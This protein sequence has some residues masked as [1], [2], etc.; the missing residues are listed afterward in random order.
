MI[1]RIKPDDF[2]KRFDIVGCFLLHEGSFVLLHRHAH[3]ASGNTWGLP[4]GK[5]DAGETLSAAVVREAQEETGVELKEEDVQFFNSYYVR[6]GNFDLG[7]HMFSIEL[8]TRPRIQIE[9]YEHQD[10]KWVTPREAQLL[11]L[12]HDLRRSIELF[13]R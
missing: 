13:F 10:Y 6:D 7:W 8:A 3:K 11:P 1:S 9:P 4:A 2:N 12:I 5:V